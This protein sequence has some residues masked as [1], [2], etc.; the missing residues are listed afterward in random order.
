[1]RSHNSLDYSDVCGPKPK[2]GGTL[3]ARNIK[4]A[5]V[6]HE[7]VSINP[8]SKSSR[9]MTNLMHAIGP[10]AARILIDANM[11]RQLNRSSPDHLYMS[12]DSAFGPE[13][14]PLVR[15]PVTS[16]LSHILT[17]A[18]SPQKELASSSRMATQKKESHARTES[19]RTPETDRIHPPTLVL[20]PPKVPRDSDSSSTSP[21]QSRAQKD[22]SK[23]YAS[24][25][26][27]S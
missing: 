14:K 11:I 2:L 21:P 26:P 19:Y 24:K 4:P 6:V 20:S 27:P 23:M 25:T 3:V 16:H 12:A 18:S 17:A 5:A 9:R 13:K 7:S 15:S 10:E 1:M 22:I 8:Y